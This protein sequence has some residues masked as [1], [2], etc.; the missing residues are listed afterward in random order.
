MQLGQSTNQPGNQLWCLEERVVKCETVVRMQLLQRGARL[1]VVVL[2]PTWLTLV[3]LGTP[4]TE[5]DLS[6][7]QFWVVI[8]LFHLLEPP[9]DLLHFIPFYNFIKMAFVLW[10][11]AP[12]NISGS[13]VVF[14][15]VRIFFCTAKLIKIGDPPTC[16]TVGVIKNETLVIVNFSAQDAS[17]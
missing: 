8:S 14:K 16:Y 3:A 13:R 15:A 5:D 12:G 6:W 2:L 11:L 10:C 4:D 9:L 1:L 17:I 7:L